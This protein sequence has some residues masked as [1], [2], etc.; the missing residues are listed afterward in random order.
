[1]GKGKLAT[2]VAHAAV[3]AYEVARTKKPEWVSEWMNTGQKKII[4]KVRSLDELKKIYEQAL[5]MD[6]PAV[7]IRDSG[8]TQIPPG[9]IT[10]TG[11]GPA[12]S[13]LIDKITGDLKLL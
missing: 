9:T 11:L 8:L 5:A 4:L 3:S 2:Q 10:A 7:L 1:M 13:E 12:P 6:I